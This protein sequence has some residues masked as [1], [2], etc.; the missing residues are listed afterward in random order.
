MC[1]S[2]AQWLMIC[3]SAT[4]LI[5]AETVRVRV[6]D[7]VIIG[8]TV[9]FSEKR[10]INVD[11]LVDVFL[12]V[13]YAD[14]PERFSPPKP[15]TP[16]SGY[17]NAT[18]FKPACMQPVY[19]N[20]PVVD[21]DCLYL[22]LFVP[23]PK[24]N[25]AAVLVFIHGGTFVTGSAMTYMYYGVPLAAVGDVI[26]VT[27]NYRVGIFS[28]FTT[29]DKEAPG[30]VGMIDQV[31]A[32]SWIFYN[33]RAFGGDPGRITLFGQSAGSGSVD[34]LMLS[35]LSRGF[36]TQAIMQ[37]GNSF[38]R[39][40]FEDTPVHRDRNRAFNLGSALGCPTTD[41]SALVS[42]LRRTDSRQLLRTAAQIYRKYPVFVDGYFLDDTPANLY[43]LGEFKRCPLMA[44]YMKDEGT[45]ELMWYFP[46]RR[47]T[48]YRPRVGA[49]FFRNTV[50]RGLAQSGYSGDE[51]RSLTLE[52]YAN[53]SSVN[54]YSTD[55]FQNTVDFLTDVD[56]ACTTEKVL[57]THADYGQGTLFKYIFT[58]PSSK[59]VFQYRDILPSTPWL[60]AG[61]SEDLIYVFGMPFIDELYHVRGHNV[62][63]EEKAL[64]VKIMK[65]W[66]NFAKSGHPGKSCRGGV[67]PTDGP[68]AWPLYDVTE[69]RHKELSL[70]L[71][72]SE[73]VIPRLHAS[74]GSRPRWAW[75]LEVAGIHRIH[76]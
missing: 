61:H 52:I 42:C 32:L 65:A 18:E 33:I 23:H 58:H 41:T 38:S 51:F 28:R 8:K 27:I 68:D 67:T 74:Q 1:F 34:F 14:P 39:W 47:G 13:P 29:R 36:F 24:P 59:N 22:N 4:L 12:G 70:E 71:E 40:A 66:T 16:W 53:W 69:L 64:S 73:D 56:Y 48:P 3:C 62:T 10:H 55:F 49:L 15:K 50:S 9:Q 44:G 5:T 11:K 57:R 20:F 37:S 43:E 26:V 19:H 54:Y 35:K 6:H 75:S 30:N 17:I 2:R 45:T 46:A 31:A 21:E 7:G 63:E 72:K 60:K 76:E 25:H